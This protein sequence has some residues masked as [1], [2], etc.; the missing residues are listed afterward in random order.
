VKRGV[1]LPESK[2]EIRVRVRVWRVC[3]GKRLAEKQ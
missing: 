2:V 1:K 3:K